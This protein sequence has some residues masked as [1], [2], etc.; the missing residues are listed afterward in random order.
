MGPAHTGEPDLC[1]ALGCLLRDAEGA[2]E[3]FRTWCADL[4][5]SDDSIKAR[6]MWR[7]CSRTAAALSRLF[8]SA[9]LEGLREL[10]AD[11]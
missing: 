11:F 7:A 3:S 5:F 8:T 10:F 9:E 6:N 2:G 1:D 4:G